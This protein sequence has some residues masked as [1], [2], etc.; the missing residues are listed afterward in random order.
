MA[1]THLTARACAAARPK[2]GPDGK[3]IQTAFPDDDPRGL[4][5]RVSAEGRK[6]WCFRYRTLE[7]RQCRIT[8]GVFAPGEDDEPT[9]AE[10]DGKPEAK[11]LTLK[12]ARRK[13]R[14]ARAVVEDGGDPAALKRNVKATAKAE[15][16]RTFDQLAD[17]YLA[18]CERGEWRPKGRR[19]RERT[20]SDETNILKRHIRPALGDLAVKDVSRATVK[21][22]L[23]GMV[24]KGIA[25]QTNR[26]HA[27]VRQ[28]YSWA[29]AEERV[30][31]NPAT[32]F[33]PLAEES[34]RARTLTDAELKALWAVLRNPGKPTI[35][36]E[37]KEPR[38]F[39]LSRPVAI[40]LQLA[41]LLL[42][43]RAEI[44]GMR[45]AELNLEEGTWLL[46]AERTKSGR[47]HMIPLPPRAVA[48]IREG[49]A[50][51]TFGREKTPACVFP[52]AR[53]GAKA[54]RADSVSHALADAA[55]VCG[56]E[57]ITV[58]DLRR[59]GATAMASERLGVAPFLVSRVLGHISDL[60][61]AAA[62]T[63]QHYALYDYAPEKRRALE[64]WSDLLQEVVGERPPRAARLTAIL[65]GRQ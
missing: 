36:V 25:A 59:T 23:R 48:L 18:A 20:L 19:K 54:I 4:E 62:V 2:A 44:S 38:T 42:Q 43:R 56:I 8:L 63:L 26:A 13:A 30:E 16:L 45:V 27:V 7:G 10:P 55:R 47:P 6:V 21:K 39:Y 33:A 5:L 46:P 51:A 1:A 40:I 22:M 14:Q 17:A 31:T 3:P 61:G 28:I 50:L 15:T 49:L 64:A 37:G 41:A 9:E 32:G 24:A 12:A 57:G 53:D 58:H 29:I 34:P 65:G 60:G 35:E 11:P 52:G